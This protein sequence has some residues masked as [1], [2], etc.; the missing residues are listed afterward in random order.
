MSIDT[1]SSLAPSTKAVRCRCHSAERPRVQPVPKVM[2]W[3]AVPIERQRTRRRTMGSFPL[4]ER[5]WM[6]GRVFRE[7]PE[8]VHRVSPL[9]RAFIAFGFGTRVERLAS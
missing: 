1:E 2:V 4:P 3:H 9:F 8:S 5:D 6:A 7:R